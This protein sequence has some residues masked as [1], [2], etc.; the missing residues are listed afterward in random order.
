MFKDRLKAGEKAWMVKPLLY[1]PDDLN[2]DARLTLK[3][4]AVMQAPVIRAHPAERG[5][6]SRCLRAH[7]HLS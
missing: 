6:G 7:G 3:S 1:K 5:V 4:K 2:L